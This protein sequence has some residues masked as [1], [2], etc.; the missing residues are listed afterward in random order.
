MSTKLHAATLAAGAA[1][2]GLA[3]APA[4]ARSGDAAQLQYEKERAVCTKGL[5]NQDRA[6]CLKEAS[7]ALQEARR[8]RL[9]DAGDRELEQNRLARCNA[10]TG[11]DRDDC[12]ARMQAGST[13]GT[14]Q[15]GGILREVSRPA[16]P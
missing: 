5:S 9:S 7:A 3:S 12:V 16:K 14:A 2:L 15:G 1:V 11:A 4:L 6:T 10:Q 13:T 8:G